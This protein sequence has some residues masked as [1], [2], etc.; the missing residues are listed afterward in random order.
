MKI[1]TVSA[2]TPG[3]ITTITSEEWS[4]GDQRRS[5]TY[6]PTG[7]PAYD[8]GSGTSSAYT[9]VS[10]LKRTWAQE[11]GPRPDVSPSGLRGC[12][13]AGVALPLLFRFGLPALGT[14]ASALP[15]TV[16]RDLRTAIS[17]GTL[18]EAGRQRVDGIEAIELTSRPGS[19]I[20]E[21]I[22][23]SPGTD[24]PVRV[25]VLDTPAPG[26]PV[27]RNSQALVRQTADII[28]LRL[29]AQNLAELAVP[30]AAGFRRIPVL[31][32]V[33]P[34]LEGGPKVLCLGPDRRP[35]KGTAIGPAPDRRPSS[36]FPA[37]NGLP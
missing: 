7:H 12:G 23:V 30:I 16:V 4:Y 2:G 33:A 9:V 22:W 25:V 26:N 29:T 31:S 35:C 11:P 27:L 13:P 8:E 20:S 14:N 18:T 37:S 3:G 17:C 15:A 24:L 19:P 32:V 5:V 10:Y 34:I 36:P 1:T 6:S 28:W 21:T